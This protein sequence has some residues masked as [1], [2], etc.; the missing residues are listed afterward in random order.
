M[1]ANET[2]T[3]N[4]TTT[5]SE[6]ISTE[7]ATSTNPLTES[8]KRGVLLSWGDATFIEKDGGI[9]ARGK[10]DG[11]ALFFRATIGS[12]K[13]SVI[14]LKNRL[15]KA[16]VQ[17]LCEGLNKKGLNNSVVDKYVRRAVEIMAENG[18]CHI[19]Q[20]KNDWFVHMDNQELKKFW[21]DYKEVKTSK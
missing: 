8:V 13:G 5:T 16:T 10:A 14:S 1:N 15:E 9:V 19:C 4:E 20:G 17:G 3:I 12:F 21:E 6:T 7:T 11:Y 18:Y 2:A